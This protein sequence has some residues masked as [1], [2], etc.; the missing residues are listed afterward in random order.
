[1]S[2]TAS[3]CTKWDLR[4]NKTAFNIGQC[5]RLIFERRSQSNSNFK[6]A[7]LLF[8]FSLITFSPKYEQDRIFWRL[9][10]VR[11]SS[12]RPFDVYTKHHKSNSK[13]THILFHSETYW[14][15]PNSEKKICFSKQQ[16]KNDHLKRPLTS[17]YQISC[18]L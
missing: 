14:T 11:G 13:K 6:Q 4:N 8:L 1:M 5:Q 7:N 2:S 16:T 3:H 9:N 12:L 18:K 10:Q 15:L 17:T